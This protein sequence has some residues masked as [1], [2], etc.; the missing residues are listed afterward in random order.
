MAKSF[1][2]MQY[3][4]KLELAKTYIMM[5]NNMTG[6]CK[7]VGIAPSV[8]SSWKKTK[9]FQD[10][11]T[12]LQQADSIELSPKLKNIVNRSLELV[13]DRLENGDFFYDPRLGKIVRREISLRDAHAVLK[14]T[15]NMQENIEKASSETQTQMTIQETLQQ[16]AKN[17]EEL[18]AKQKQKAPVQVTD[19]LFVNEDKE[20]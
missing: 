18:A 12:N 2:E 9:V 3:A 5:G 6:A 11:L 4:R 16:L 17:F 14:D 19:V 7:A 15:V 20:S 10:I 13:Q 8:G 1:K